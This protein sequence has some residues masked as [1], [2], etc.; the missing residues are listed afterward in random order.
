[1]F[2]FCL[3]IE[4][5]SE[6]IFLFLTQPYIRTMRTYYPKSYDVHCI[7]DAGKISKNTFRDKKHE[8]GQTIRARSNE[9]NS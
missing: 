8:S 2:C 5:L 7:A 3:Q 4:N 1:M 9:K 6:T